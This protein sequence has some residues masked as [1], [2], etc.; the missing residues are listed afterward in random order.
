VGCRARRGFRWGAQPQKT[1]PSETALPA[2]PRTGTLEA[3]A[4]STSPA[5]ADLPA[6]G[7][8]SQ[9][10]PPSR[11]TASGPAG[12]TLGDAP[13]VG[14]SQ[15]RRRD[16]GRVM[17]AARQG[18]RDSAGSVRVD[19]SA[20]QVA[21]VVR[22][23]PDGGSPSTLLQGLEGV[24]GALAARPE[25]LQNPRLSRSLLFGFVLLACL[26]ADGSYIGVM[27]LA[28]RSGRSPSSTRRYLA[29]LTAAGVVERN[30]LTRGYRLAL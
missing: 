26:P 3:M 29:T 13:P 14:A 6:C 4:T 21:E 23:A 8:R 12:A 11:A 15:D 16:R 24:R 22:A 17:M 25:E 2:T 20:D 9:A 7:A 18:R 19:L 27:E 1:E 30:P 10:L 5:D 28:K